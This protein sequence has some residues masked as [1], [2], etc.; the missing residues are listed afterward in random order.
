MILAAGLS[1]AWQQTVVL[2]NLS[3]GEVNRAREVHWCASGKVLNVGLAA[4]ALATDRRLKVMTIAPVG[5]E[6]GEAIRHDFRTLGIPARWVHSDS[7]TRVCTTILDRGSGKTTELVE[8]AHS[9]R[10]S[11]VTRFREAFCEELREA[12]LI[13]LSGSLPEGAPV[14]LYRELTS[15]SS[16]RVIIDCQGPPLLAALEASPFLVKPNREEL[17]RTLG[18]ALGTDAELHAAMRELNR[19]GAQWVVVTE[20]KERV[21]ISSV[22]RLLSITPPTVTAVNPIGSGDSLAA[23]I[24][25]AVADGYDLPE[26]VAWGVAAA[27]TN[28]GSL[29]PA[30]FNLGA[31]KSLRPTIVIEDHSKTL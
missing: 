28:A 4:S 7:P 26:A 19:L 22:D 1:P 10:S 11:D 27:A 5:G 15:E 21:W 9:V 8:N 6:T 16:A 24:A 2:D 3:V 14:W 29:L 12:K 30:R 17:G 31:V 13:V 20:G 23:G 18:R 25:V